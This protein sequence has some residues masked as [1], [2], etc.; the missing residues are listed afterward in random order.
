MHFMAEV[1]ARWYFGEGL[2]IALC[3]VEET[4]QVQGVLDIH[5]EAVLGEIQQQEYV[6]SNDW[7][8]ES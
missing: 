2:D 3:L 8:H 4:H 7:L 6:W 5:P 1:N